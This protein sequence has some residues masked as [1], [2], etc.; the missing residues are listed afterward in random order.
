M[1]DLIEGQHL[2]GHL[3]TIVEGN[4]H[5][6]VDLKDMLIGAIGV[7]LYLSFELTRLA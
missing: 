3:A 1:T 7:G 4:S 6:V 5:P 2:T